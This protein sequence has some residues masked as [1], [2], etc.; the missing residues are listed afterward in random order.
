MRAPAKPTMPAKPGKP[1]K[2]APPRKPRPRA[3]EPIDREAAQADIERELTDIE[4]GFRERNAKEMAR[5]S[6]ATDNKYYFCVVLEDGAQ[7]DALLDALGVLGKGDLYVDGRIVAK[8][9]GVE[10]PKAEKGKSSWR[11]DKDL[12]AIAGFEEE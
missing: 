11:T 9:L 6:D 1:R 10:L 2:P 3:K 5:N 7:A 8:A 12:S 4:R